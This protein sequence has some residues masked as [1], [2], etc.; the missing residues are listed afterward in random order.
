MITLT[1]PFRSPQSG[2]QWASLAFSG[3]SDWFA[4][5]S[6]TPAISV[7]I[8]PAAG[9]TARAEYT[10]SSPAEIEAGTAKWIPWPLG[11]VSAS[12]SDA[13]LTMCVAIRGVASGGTAAIEVL[14]R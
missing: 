6:C 10:L 12:S 2:L 7:A 14:A 8:H 5:P 4:V 3:T 13:L 11:D 9:Q 1:Y